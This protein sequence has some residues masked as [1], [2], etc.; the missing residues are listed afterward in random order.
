MEYGLIGEKL[1]HSYS[2]EI[3][4]LIGN[5]EYEL[6]EISKTNLEVFMTEKK[7]KG[8]NVTIPYKQ[9]VIPF[10]DYIDEPAR[11]IGAVNTVV[12][13]SGKLYGYNTDF[14]GLKKLILS[15]KI[16]IKGKKVLV[17]GTGGTSKTATAVLKSLEAA[18]IIIV[19]RKKSQETVTYEEAVSCYDDAR[20]IVNTTPCGMFPNI[21]AEPIHLEAFKNLEAVIDVVYNP[22]RTRLV[23][24][25]Q[26]KNIKAAGGLY[27]LVYQAISAAEYFFEEPVDACKADKI[28]QN[29]LLHKQNVVLTG[30][31]GSGKSTVGKQLA[32]EL[33]RKYFD[34]DEI[35]TELYK[36]TPAQII[37]EEGENSFREKEAFVCRNLADKTDAVISTGG[38]AVLKNENV[39]HLKNNG[40]IFFLDRS[41]E[42]LL[43]TD[44][45]PLSD[46]MEKLIKLYK[47]RHP[48]YIANADFCVK[49]DG[50]VTE[51]V[52][53]I[54]QELISAGKNFGGEK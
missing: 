21:D 16:E 8:I 19:S 27:M 54:K 39:I 9:S 29:L 31:P 12:N 40:I 51:T 18:E 20:I 49:N 53:K 50:E 32:F 35:I 17:L 15:Q 1:G 37:M 13:R 36:K 4:N 43:P 42:N 25:A 5:Y 7:F 3:H 38:G 45:R 2:K 52:T 14:V 48:I 47:I 23:I 28:Y 34:T 24:Q 26:Q 10:L 46:S 41:I 6:K 11:E 33:S 44:D 22:L 30:M